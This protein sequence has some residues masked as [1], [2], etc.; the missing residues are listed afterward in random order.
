[1]GI[2][3]TGDDI[4]VPYEFVDLQRI[5]NTLYGLSLIYGILLL[6]NV[7]AVNKY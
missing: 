4:D 1:M 5:Y 2:K 7:I 3:T 6:S